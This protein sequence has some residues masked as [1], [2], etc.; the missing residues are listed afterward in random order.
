MNAAHRLAD[1]FRSVISYWT[2]TPTVSQFV[3]KGTLTPQEFV[4]AGDQLVFKFPTW[5]W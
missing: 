3:E 5:K 2:P 4:E 1:G